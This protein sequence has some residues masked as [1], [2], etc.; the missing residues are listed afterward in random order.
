MQN[1]VSIKAKNFV[2]FGEDPQGFDYI[3][4]INVIIGKNNSGKSALLKLIRYV[5][6]NS[7]SLNS[8][9][10]NKKN[11]TVYIKRDITQPVIDKTF[12]KG[13]SGGHMPG[14]DHWNYGVSLLGK[15][16]T[17]QFQDGNNRPFTLE[18]NPELMTE[19]TNDTERNKR[20][21]H[22]AKESEIPH[23]GKQYRLISAERDIKREPLSEIAQSSDVLSGS[24]EG[25]TNLIANFLNNKTLQEAKVEEELLQALSEIYGDDADFSRIQA[26]MD[27]SSKEYEIYL[28]E[29][30]KGERVAL[31]DSGSSLKTVLLVLINLILIPEFY[32]KDMSKYIFA[33]EE[34]ENNLHPALQRRLLAY[35][36]KTAEEKECIF[37]LTTHSNVFIDIFSHQD[38]SQILHIKHDG[39]KAI[40][41]NVR[42]HIEK[43]NVLDDL[44]FRASDVLQANGVLWVEGPTDRIYLKKWIDIWSNGELQEDIHYQFVFYGGSVRKHLSASDPE[45]VDS[46]ISVFRINKNAVIVM[47][48]DRSKKGQKL[49]NSKTKLIDEL[50]DSDTSTTFVT[51]GKDIENYINPK[52]IKEYLKLEDEPRK[53]EQYEEF[54]DYLNEL[55]DGRGKTFENNKMLFA[56]KVKDLFKKEDL[57]DMYDIDKQMTNIVALIQKWNKLD[58]KA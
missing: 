20:G 49:E 15:D 27:P 35:L 42:T 5:A 50:K 52:T 2:C 23:Q 57:K 43:C 48:S 8:F 13:S 18:D 41:E 26:Q 3:Y 24:G 16:I 38:N 22:I 12:Q 28:E 34:L 51:K 39:E 1:K 36:L 47:D 31:S 4:P 19:I 7:P 56:D 55:Q 40:V 37:F 54:S 11:P 33:F 17:F 14:G 46:A 10:H 29:K 6:T 44:D 30:K 25:A 32:K 9:S 45:Q 53:V 58:K 21:E